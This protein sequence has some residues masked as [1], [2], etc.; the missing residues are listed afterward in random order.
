MELPPAIC[1]Y[2]RGRRRIDRHRRIKLRGSPRV[3]LRCVL[4]MMMLSTWRQHWVD[5][6][7][8]LA[9]TRARCLRFTALWPWHAVSVRLVALSHRLAVEV[10]V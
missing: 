3:I 1:T 6:I 9:F 4:Q 5:V 2:L 8:A 7:R 10:S